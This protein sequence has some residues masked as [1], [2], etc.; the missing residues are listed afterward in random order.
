MDFARS[1]KALVVL[2]TGAACLLAACGGGSTSGSGGTCARVDQVSQGNATVRI[3]NLGSTM[4]EAYFGDKVA[5]AADLRPGECNLIGIQLPSGYTLNTQVEITQCTPDPADGCGAKY[6]VTKNEPLVLQPGQSKTITVDAGYFGSTSG[7]Y[8]VT[9][10]LLGV[11][12]PSV[13][14]TLSGG[15]S[16]TATGSNGGYAFT[17]LQNGTY[18]VTPWAAGYTFTPASRQVVVQGANVSGQDFTGTATPTYS[19]SGSVAGAATDSV[20]VTLT[21][22]V[23]SRSTTTASGGL[24]AFSGLPNGTYTLTPS[25]MGFTFSPPSAQV[26]INGASMSGTSFIALPTYSIS[27][28]VVGAVYGGVRVTL[29]GAATRSTTTN[30]AGLFQFTEISNGTYTLTPSLAGYTFTPP[31]QQVVVNGGYVN[32]ITFTAS[33]TAPSTRSI[34]GA[35]SGAATDGVLVTLSGATS[36]STTTGGGGLYTFTGLADGTYT[37]TPTLAGYSFTPASRQLTVN[38]SDA[39]G[40]SFTATAVPSTHSISGTIYGVPNSLV[41]LTLSGAASA[42]INGANAGAG[43]VF[44]GLANGTY[45]VTPSGAGYEFAPQSRQVVVQDGNL[46]GVDFA[47]KDAG[48]ATY[49]ISGVVSGAATDGVLMTLGGNGGASTTTTAGGVYYFAWPPNGTYTITPTKAGLTFT[50]NS[51]QVTVNGANVTGVNF[52]ANAA[53]QPTVWDVTAQYSSTQNPSGAWSY[54]WKPAAVGDGFTLMTYKLVNQDGTFW[55]RAYGGAPGIAA[56]G[57]YPSPMLWAGQNTS[58]LPTIRW[59]CPSSGTYRI[60]TTFTATDTA[61][62]RILVSIATGNTALLSGA[63]LAQGTTAPYDGTVSLQAG[64]HVDF[65]VAWD[66]STPYAPGGWTGIT[67]TVSTVTQ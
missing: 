54:G 16:A 41:T 38:G 28:G 40:V 37:V 31:S 46:S 58:G 2:L 55:A 39:T 63:V 15:T 7:S 56:P 5:F 12:S 53:P 29:S 60:Q 42:I 32:G 23:T 48:T 51:Q 36:R 22:S 19:I 1:R 43:F 52:V 13:T 61:G 50:P 57:F 35:V 67:G 4:I 21:G 27:G 20:T 44:A 17:G 11:N 8:S 62:N 3:E 6:G 65:L 66:S 45:T 59:T 18:T 26:V 47:G 64:D 25:R 9:G 33:S 14:L 34:S 10:S 30:G 24:F 49:Y